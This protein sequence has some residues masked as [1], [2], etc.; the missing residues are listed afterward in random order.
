MGT[1]SSGRRVFVGPNLF[2]ARKRRRVML[3]RV[4][5]IAPPV[6]VSFRL[7]IDDNNDRTD[8]YQWSLKGFGDFE[9]WS[10]K[11]QSAPT[12]KE[13]KGR[14]VRRRPWRHCTRPWPSA[15][16]DRDRAGKSVCR[17]EV[18]RMESRHECTV[19]SAALQ[20]RSLCRSL[21]C[22]CQSLT[23]WLWGAVLG[24]GCY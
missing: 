13:E 16:L 21:T 8:A 2:G 9:N 3:F 20:T 1:F 5:I 7:S 22:G 11:V 4:S 6:A 17:L 19:P 18:P 23:F 10:V 24:G 12:R 14:G 15:G